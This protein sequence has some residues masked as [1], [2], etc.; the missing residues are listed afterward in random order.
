MRDGIYYPD[1]DETG[2]H[3]LL[4]LGLAAGLVVLGKLEDGA[5]VAEPLQRLLGH[6][7]QRQE[8]DDGHA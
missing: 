3:L 5:V 8:A 1:K 7:P 2:L 4:L 6:R